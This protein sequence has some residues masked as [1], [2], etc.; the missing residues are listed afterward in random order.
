MAFFYD[1]NVVI[2][3]NDSTYIEKLVTV[4]EHGWYT[5]STDMGENPERDFNIRRL[6][7]TE[8][9]KGVAEHLVKRTIVVYFQSVE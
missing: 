5:Y 1:A 6:T 7:K 8:A 3:F 2:L 4:Q 9:L